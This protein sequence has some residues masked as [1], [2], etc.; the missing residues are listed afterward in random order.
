MTTM[1]S[2]CVI[3]VIVVT[4]SVIVTNYVSLSGLDA[5]GAMG[6]MRTVLAAMSPSPH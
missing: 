5:M 4:N 1:V 6:A 2:N 3:H